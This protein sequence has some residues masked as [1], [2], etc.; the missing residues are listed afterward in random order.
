MRGGW[1]GLRNREEDDWATYEALKSRLGVAT[2]TTGS[3][4]SRSYLYI[5]ESRVE[6]IAGLALDL[7][8]MAGRQRP[9]WNRRLDQY[10]RATGLSVRRCAPHWWLIAYYSQ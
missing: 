4:T 7:G 3:T 6:S 8:A 1:D 2:G 10:A 9:E 5:V